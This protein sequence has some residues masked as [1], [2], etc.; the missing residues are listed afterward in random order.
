M[1]RERGGGFERV[2]LICLE[3][4]CFNKPK[5]LISFHFAA[6]PE[7]RNKNFSRTK[8]FRA[9][10]TLDGGDEKNRIKITDASFQ[11]FARILKIPTARGGGRRWRNTR[12]ENLR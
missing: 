3:L 6:R 2:F 9:V 1:E 11:Y 12:F 10:S 8:I 4:E 5:V 7:C